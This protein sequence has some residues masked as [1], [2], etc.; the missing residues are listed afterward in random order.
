MIIVYRL[1]PVNR[2]KCPVMLPPKCRFLGDYIKDCPFYVGNNP[3]EYVD[4]SEHF[5]H[6]ITN[7]LTV[8]AHILK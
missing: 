4:S 1:T 8:N 6:V 3:I 5:G 7:Q 2:I